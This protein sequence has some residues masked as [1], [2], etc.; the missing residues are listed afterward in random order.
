VSAVYVRMGV[1]GEQYALA[2]EQV[3][4]VLSLGDVTP[5]P[6]APASVLG[7]LNLRGEILSVV[8]LASALGLRGESAPSRLIVAD[9][10]ARRAGL[11]I[12]QVLDV[13]PL[14]ENLPEDGLGCVHETAVLDGALVGVIDLAA[15]LDAAAGGR[16]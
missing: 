9:D 15:L 14:L 8:E 10:G 2:V 4:E 13:A 12:D 16:S 5:V 11:A 6:G 3:A 7:L 1:A